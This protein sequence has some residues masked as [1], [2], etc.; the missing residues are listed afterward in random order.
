MALVHAE[1][2]NSVV[3]IR[4]PRLPARSPPRQGRSS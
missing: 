1:E 2:N 4:G 3:G